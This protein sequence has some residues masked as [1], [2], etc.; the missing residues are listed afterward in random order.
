MSAFFGL[1]I[2]IDIFNSLNARTERL[3]I[4]ANILKNKVFIIII[5]LI[6]IIQI[7]MIYYGGNMFRTIGLSFKELEVMI[8]LA[9]S[10]IPVDILRK[11]IYKKKKK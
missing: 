3:N 2:F 10:V 1:F 5:L 11:I 6:V 9:S 7:I 4:F 8:L